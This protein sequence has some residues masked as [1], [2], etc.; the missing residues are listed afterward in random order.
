MFEAIAIP[1]ELVQQPAVKMRT[2]KG[3]RGDNLGRKT[4]GIG[5][6]CLHVIPQSKTHS[7]ILAIVPR[8]Q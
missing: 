8:M 6:M 2:R 1:V 3:K 4:P 5:A 7:F